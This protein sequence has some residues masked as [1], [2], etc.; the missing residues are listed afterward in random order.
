MAA[1]AWGSG[2][3]LGTFCGWNCGCRA[4]F[5]LAQCPAGN[6]QLILKGSRPT[7]SKESRNPLGN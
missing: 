4:K 3:R 2:G 1:N 5:F 7:D 6:F